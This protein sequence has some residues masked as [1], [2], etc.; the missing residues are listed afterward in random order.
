MENNHNINLNAAPDLLEALEEL[1]NLEVK[2]H[3][4]IDRLQFTNA[5]R[6]L[7]DKIL[8]AIIKAKG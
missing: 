3:S 7:S 1:A 6:A 5:G 8:N 2:G 4:I